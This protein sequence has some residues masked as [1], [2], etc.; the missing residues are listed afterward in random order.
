MT[1]QPQATSIP[2]I[3]N[4]EDTEAGIPLGS[5]GASAVPGMAMQQPPTPQMGSAGPGTGFTAFPMTSGAGGATVAPLQAKGFYVPGAIETEDYTPLRKI[6]WIFFALFLIQA[7]IML[8]IAAPIARGSIPINTNFV[9]FDPFRRIYVNSIQD[10]G[11]F[12][13]GGYICVFLFIDAISYL[14]NAV[15]FNRLTRVW[16]RTGTDYVRYLVWSISTAWLAYIVGLSDGIREIVFSVIGFMFLTSS[17]FWFMMCQDLCN[18]NPLNRR[19]TFWWPWVFAGLI[20]VAWLII[21]WCYLF[22]YPFR[23]VA[24]KIVYAIV[25]FTTFFLLLH[26][27]F[28]GFQYMNIR[29]FRTFVSQA[30]W[31]Y[32][33]HFVF[34]T[35]IAWLLF[36]LFIWLF[37]TVN[38]NL[39]GSGTFNPF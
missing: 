39:S 37:Y 7:I 33:L 15:F 4:I 13:P 10:K 3:Y 17:F 21:T 35:L 1:Q 29:G 19:T 30:T 20:F 12:Q 24:P 38:S 5:M 16:D 36:A 28:Q 11:Y 22:S 2:V 25:I 34:H 18:G 27:L 8:C 26:W 6:N 14:I 31:Q 9:T 23:G 32:C